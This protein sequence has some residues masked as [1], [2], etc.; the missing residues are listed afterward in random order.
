MKG[1]RRVRLLLGCRHARERWGCR[2]LPWGG[3][4]GK[5]TAN[6]HRRKKGLAGAP[7]AR[8][9]RQ[10]KGMSGAGAEGMGAV[11]GGKCGRLCNAPPGVA[12]HGESL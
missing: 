7:W 8:G 5:G 3:W 12:E 11:G 2:K 1:R 10:Q 4:V 6:M 9:L